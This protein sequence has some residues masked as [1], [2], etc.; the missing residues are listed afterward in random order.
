MA[1]DISEEDVQNAI[2]QVKHPVIQ[3]QI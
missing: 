3:F 1:K 2:A